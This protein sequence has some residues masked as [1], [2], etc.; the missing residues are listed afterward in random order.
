MVIDK[1]F[2]CHKHEETKDDIFW[3]CASYRHFDCPFK[4]VT[5]KNDNA[6]DSNP[7][8][9]MMYDIESHTCSQRKLGPTLQKFRNKLKT[10]MQTDLRMKYSNIWKEERTLL[11]ASVSDSVEMTNQVLPCVSTKSESQEDAQ[12]SKGSR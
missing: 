11:L 10:R 9:A 1:I 5:K 12:D 3:R 2:V 4:V 7:E 8:V 6:N